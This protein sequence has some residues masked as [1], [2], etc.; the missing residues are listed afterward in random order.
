LV[1]TVFIVVPVPA[2][3]LQG[4]K[5]CPE[6]LDGDAPTFPGH[7]RFGGIEQVPHDLPVDGWI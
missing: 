6:A 3:V 2:L 7:L 1:L 5:S 4:K